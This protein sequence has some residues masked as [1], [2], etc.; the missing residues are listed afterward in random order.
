MQKFLADGASLIQKHANSLAYLESKIF[1]FWGGEAEQFFVYCCY[2]AILQNELAQSCLRRGG[3][4]PILFSEKRKLLFFWES[5]FES[6][7]FA[8]FGNCSNTKTFILFG[9][10]LF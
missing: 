2:Q 9:D 6:K 3:I 7:N 5:Y 4:L 1:A 8:H 10:Q